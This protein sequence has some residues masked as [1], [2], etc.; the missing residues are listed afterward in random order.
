MRLISAHR[1]RFS[2]GLAVIG[3]TTSL[4]LA[5][6][7]PSDSK[8]KTVA[9]AERIRKDLDK[10]IDFESVDQPLNLA[11]NQLREQCKINFVLDRQTLALM[12]ID[13]EQTPVQVKFKAA[14]VK[15]VLRSILTAHN[16]SYAIVG[17]IVYISTDEMT[18][19]RQMQQRVNIDLEKMEFTA[20][21]RQLGKETA[22]NLI[23]DSRVAKE[24]GQVVSLQ[25]EDVPLETAVRLMAEMVGLK[26]VRIG[27]VLFVCSKANAQELRADPELVARPQPNPN[28]T[29]DMLV[30][31][32]GGIPGRA[33]APMV[34]PPAP[35]PAPEKKA[36][37]E[38]EKDDPPG[39]PQR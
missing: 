35:N 14:R 13:P 22:T 1:V 21:L 32:P 3:L 30:V 20:A 28:P 7:L 5:A 38:K 9:P 4:L 39:K 18:M 29:P 23:V 15:T 26:P 6:P 12:N 19:F 11:L 16:L 31:P 8:S 34:P 33:V 36:A 37:P 17:D 2:V 10:I 24:A 25:A 27:N